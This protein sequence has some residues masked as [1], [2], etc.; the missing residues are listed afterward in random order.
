MVCMTLDCVGLTQF[1]VI[2][3]I[4]HNVGLKFFYHLP[5]CLL[6]L[7]VFSYTYISQSSVETHLRCG[8]MYNNCYCEMSSESASEKNYEHLSIIRKDMDTNK[9]SH[10]LWPTV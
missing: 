7:L 3:I 4:H 9:V 6:L 8:G 1:S 2:W 5:K 10:F